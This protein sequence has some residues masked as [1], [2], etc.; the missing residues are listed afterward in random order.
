MPRY[1]SHFRTTPQHEDI[2]RTERLK[3]L[4]SR[5]DKT[6][7]AEEIASILLAAHTALLRND[8]AIALADI[9][10]DKEK[11]AE[12]ILTVLGRTSTRHKRGTLLYALDEL[13][14]HVP[15][16][17]LVEVVITDWY[18][19]Q[20]EAL[21]LIQKNLDHYRSTDKTKAVAKLRA[22]RAKPILHK[23]PQDWRAAVDRAIALLR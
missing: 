17:P 5:R 7:V 16:G 12:A 1:V 8:A 6:G 21:H 18:E 14:A 20:Q 11:A 10:S 2:A 23:Y 15:L 22:A 9:A 3:S 13:N 4:V 19:A